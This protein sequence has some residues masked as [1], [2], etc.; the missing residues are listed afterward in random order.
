[1]IDV[2]RKVSLFNILATGVNYKSKV[3]LLVAILILPPGKKNIGTFR[4]DLGAKFLIN[5][6]QEMKSII[7]AC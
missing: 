2:F 1:M 5:D 7:K 4:R 6:P 3:V